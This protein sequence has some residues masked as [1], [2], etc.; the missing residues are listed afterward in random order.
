MFLSNPTASKRF[1]FAEIYSCLQKS[2]RRDDVPLCLELAKE[3]QEYPNALKKRLIYIT[4]E[5][6]PDYRMVYEIYKTPSNIMDLIKWIPIV[7]EH[8]KTRAGSDG[9]RYAVECPLV[10]HDYDETK[11]IS[12]DYPSTYSR[13]SIDLSLERSLTRYA[14]IE[15]NVKQM[16]V[17][18]AYMIK[19]HEEEKALNWFDEWLSQ[20]LF[21]H[22]YKRPTRVKTIY[23]FINKVRNV[24][25]GLCVYVTTPGIRTYK[26]DE[27]SSVVLD[28]TSIKYKDKTWSL[29]M[30]E[31]TLKSLPVYTYDKHVAGGNETYE[32]FFKNLI[33]SPRL[34]MPKVEIYGVRRYLESKE[35]ANKALFTEGYFTHS[36]IYRYEAMK[37]TKEME[38]P[39]ITDAKHVITCLAEEGTLEQTLQKVISSWK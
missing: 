28:E 20:N 39:P 36:T 17:T 5:D 24:L 16:L 37:K 29:N 23:N 8:V 32:F 30:K 13:S 35:G 21:Y 26:Q 15:E 1:Q 6:I 38:D 25:L 2:I 14:D 3:F 27:I 22:H 33:L 18:T 4:V 31:F 10:F 9:Y 12:L 7:C 11:T 19:I 34:P